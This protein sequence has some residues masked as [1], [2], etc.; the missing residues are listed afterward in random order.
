[1]Y[2]LGSASSY[3]VRNNWDEGHG[4]HF[5]KKQTHLYHTNSIAEYLASY[6][7]RISI[8]ITNRKKERDNKTEKKYLQLH[9]AYIPRTLAAIRLTGKVL[10]L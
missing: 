7:H 1:M 3:P 4:S 5:G 6:R 9:E 8:V 10:G 2:V